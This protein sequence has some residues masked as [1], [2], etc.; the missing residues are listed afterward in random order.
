VRDTSVELEAEALAVIIQQ[1]IARRIE[2]ASI[3]AHE[4]TTP[5][6]SEL[7]ESLV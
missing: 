4:T 2:Q 7:I 6:W 1:E 3:A 5:A